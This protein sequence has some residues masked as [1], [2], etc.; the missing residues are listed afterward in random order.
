M[1]G[2]FHMTLAK[3]SPSAAASIAM[4]QPS[5]PSIVMSKKPIRDRVFDEHFTGNLTPAEAEAVTGLIGR[6]AM[7]AVG[8]LE[9]HADCEV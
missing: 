6:V 2:S 8:E 1:I 7:S 9:A 3:S 5:A 4:N